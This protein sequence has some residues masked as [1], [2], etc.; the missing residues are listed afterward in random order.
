MRVLFLASLIREPPRSWACQLANTVQ[1][2]LPSNFA[3][4]LRHQC[5]GE[6]RF[7]CVSAAELKESM[8]ACEPV[9]WLEYMRTYL[10]ANFTQEVF[11]KAQAVKA[12]GVTIFSGTLEPGQLLVAPAGFIVY[13]KS[14]EG[15]SISIE[16]N[17]FDT[18]DA[19]RQGLAKL[20]PLLKD[21]HRGKMEEVL[22]KMALACVEGCD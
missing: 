13:S 3:G 8:E 7:L 4:L 15:N 6:A 18:T 17:F 10:A 5:R 22:N 14:F 16:I 11:A 2:R 20:L 9:D 21:A 1:V 19:A 12:A